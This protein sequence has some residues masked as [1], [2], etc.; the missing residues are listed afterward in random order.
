MAMG[1]VS[2]S[3]LDAELETLSKRPVIQHVVQERGRGNTNAIPDSLKQVIAEESIN[4]VPAK[5][6]NQ[7]LG[8]S[9][10]SIS[11]YKNGA[12]STASYNIPDPKLKKNNNLVRERILSKSRK[13]LLLA[14]DSI[15]GEKIEKASLKELT[16][17]SAGMASVIDKVEPKDDAKV[18][19]D[20]LMIYAPRV[21]DEQSYDVIEVRE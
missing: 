12:T 11:A 15:T 10:S 19:I 5:E 21:R 2:H 14:L 18:S 16:S 1:I 13:K 8:V 4:G 3:D 9:L 7:V 17:L 6:I 20:K